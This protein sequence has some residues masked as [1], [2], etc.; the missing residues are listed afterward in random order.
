ML[1]VR[2]TP[3]MEFEINRVASRGNGANV[4]PHRSR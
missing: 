2:L 4:V 3:K 1:T